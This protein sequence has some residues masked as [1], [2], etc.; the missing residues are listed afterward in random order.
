MRL[1]KFAVHRPIFTSMVTL[2]VIV[3]GMVSLLR[4]PI[5]LMPDITYP[6]LTVRTWYENASPE[7]ME[8]LVA[9]PLEEAIGAVPGVEMVTSVS[10]EGLCNVRSTFAWGRDLDAAANDI[11]DRLDRVIPKLPEDADRPIL[12]KFDL[13]S[14]PVVRVGVSS[15]LDPVRLRTLIDDHI[16]FRIERLAG[17]A[18]VDVRGGRERQI[19]VDLSADKI[20]ALGLPLER[21]LSRIKSGNVNLP[22]GLVERGNYE[23]MVRTP[24]E[25]HS[26]RELED[27]VLAVRES[28]PIYLRDV[29]KVKDAWEETR[30]VVRINGR[31]GI[32]LDVRKQSG[33]NTV[34]VS[35]RVVAEVERI[36][37]DIPQM[38]IAIISNTADYIQRSIRNVST[39]ALGGGA[40][41][42]LVLLL[43]LRSFGSTAVIGISIPISIIATFGLMYFGGFTLNIMTLGGLALGVGMLVDNAIVVLENIFRLREGGRAPDVAAVEGSEEVTGAIVASTLTT[44][45]VFVPLIYMGGQSGIMFKQLSLVVSFALLCS[46]GVALT[47]VPMLAA[48][49]LRPHADP[50]QRHRGWRARLFE[51]SG[52]FFENMENEY[53]ALLRSALRHRAVVIVAAALMLVGSL[54]LIRWVGVEFMPATDESEVRVYADMEVGTRMALFD[55]IFQGIERKVRAAVPEIESVYSRIGGSVW[56]PKGAHT[57]HMRLSL[58]PMAQRTRSSEQVATDLRKL[59]AN[60]P[61]VKVRTRPGQGPFVLRMFTTRE[62]KIEVEI[63]GHDLQVADELARSVKDMVQAVPGV[64][65]PDVSRESGSPEELV[66]IDRQRAS[67]MRLTVSQVASAL[68]TALSGSKAGNFRDA[69]KEYDILVKLEDAELLSMRNILDLTITNAGGEP[70]VLRNVVKIV[71]RRGPVIIERKNQQRLVTVAADYTGRDMGSVVRDI[72]RGCQTIPRP[73]DFTISMGGDYEEQVKAFRELLISFVLAIMLVY[74]VMACQFE[75]LLDPFVVMFSVPLAAIGVILMLLITHTTFNV[76][77]FIGCTMLGG[78]VVNNAILLVDHTNL[79]RRRDGMPLMEAVQEAGRRRLRPI[80]MTA[81]TTILGLTPLALGMGEGGEAQAPLAR[82][83]IGGLLSATLITLVLVPTV[84]SIFEH[85]IKGEPTA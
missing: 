31:A 74:M 69:G 47:M 9:R 27:T 12:Y 30:R 10:A 52:R 18:S 68:Q 2:I 53:A 26:L 44:L 25:Y 81:A 85:H 19:H 67:D 56:R 75:S 11:R 24:G 72:R 83:V 7:E 38:N 65:N 73:A 6:T 40:L 34:E 37:R 42:I 55:E 51:A 28:A 80:V 15:G 43:F 49:L 76:Q 59:L 39:S 32:R 29:A 82:A 4:L 48:K 84:Y 77:S 63:R 35:K 57:A 78:I 41:A 61:G 17:V 14:Y 54:C 45:V 5:D 13:A 16:K 3:L 62:E 22:G 50:G 1:S 66:M 36:N 64:V 60:I 79:L 21:I 33:A 20:K 23:V 46:L 58:V 70:V 71:P 8:E